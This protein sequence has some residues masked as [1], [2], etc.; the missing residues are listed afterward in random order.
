MAPSEI[1]QLTMSRLTAIVI[2][3]NK[4]NKEQAKKEERQITHNEMMKLQEE[5][6]DKENGN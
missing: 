1:E 5:Y 6:L 2:H 3:L 4:I